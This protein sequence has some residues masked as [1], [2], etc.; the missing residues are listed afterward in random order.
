MSTYQ[1]RAILITDEGVEI[2]VGAQ[3]R[4]WRD[5]RRASWG[6][7]LTIDGEYWDILKNKD[8]GLRLRLTNGNEATFNRPHKQD[9]PAFP[10]AP[11]F[12]TVMGD[13]DVPF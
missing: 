6:G 11:F 2:A 10:G 9:I 1:G 3:L 4:S 8:E 5:G 13:G 12:F 7:R